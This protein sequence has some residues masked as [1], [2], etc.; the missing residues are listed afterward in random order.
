MVLAIGLAWPGAPAR[1]QDD[2]FTVRGVVVDATAATA[3]AARER[4]H[5]Q[6]KRQAWERL[7]DAMAPQP[8][9]ARL[10]RLAQREL[11]TLIQSFSVDAERTGATR[12]SAELTVQFH[13]ERARA[14]LLSGAAAG[15]ASRIEVEATYSSLRDWIDI[16]RRLASVP[17]VQNTDIVSVSAASARL[18]LSASG[19]AAALVPALAQA[20]LEL[21]NSGGTWRLSLKRAE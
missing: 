14:A 17:Q 4:A 16:R 13:P 20:G 3:I 15:S 19:D 2:P 5:E 12:Y 6:G 7:V 10:K 11:E 8:D 21:A 1:A 9:Q 18:Q